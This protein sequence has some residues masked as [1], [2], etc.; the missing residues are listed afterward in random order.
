MKKCISCL[1]VKPKTDEFFFYRNKERGW[2]SSWCKNCKKEYRIQNN[3]AELS[4]QRERRGV[5]PCKTCGSNEKPKGSTYCEKCQ[6]ERHKS[7]KKADK[8]IY[9]SRLRKARPNWANKNAIRE[10]YKNCPDGFHVDHIIPIRGENVCG[11]HV[12]SNLQYLL[13]EINISKSNHYS[14]EHNGIK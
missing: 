6:S 2:F 11:L 14:I 4:K 8:C 13:A 7:R 1:T 9:K 5:K 12:E 3:E 10:T